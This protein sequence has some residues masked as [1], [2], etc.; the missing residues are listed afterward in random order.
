M[1]HAATRKGGTVT[2]S[3]F[4]ALATAC[5]LALVLTP[6]VRALAMRWGV[7]DLPAARKV[8]VAPTPLLGGVAVFVAFALAA[9]FWLRPVI[10]IQVMLLLAGAAAF[11]VV[12]L[13]DDV[14]DAGAWK[15]VLEAVI[16]TAIVWAGGFRV[17]LPWPVAGDVLAILWIV[18][19]ANAINCLDCTDGVASGVTAIAALALAGLALILGR[20]GVAV[21][22]CC[23]AG[24]ALGFLRY[25]FPPA[26]IFLG[27][28]GS[29]MMGFLLGGLGAV[30]V[31]PAISMEW[32]APLLILSVPVFD[33]LAVHVLRFR[34]GVSLRNIVTSTGRDH[35]P[36]RL[37]DAGLS[38][39]RVAWHVYRIC[40]LAGAS[41]LALVTWG[42][43]AAALPGA[44]FLAPYVGARA[45]RRPAAA[46]AQSD[47]AP[48]PT[49]ESS[50]GGWYPLGREAAN[51]EGEACD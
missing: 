17:P 47:A 20:T 48:S 16:V 37:L 38:P 49:S 32:I 41:G 7:L 44:V 6:V 30:L 2:T 8:H 40:A 50:S 1:R 13:I 9:V 39:A 12:G 31:A 33:F 35:L 46:D 27:D 42:P 14:W 45:R 19:V 28:A 26:R 24:A 15:L 51:Q 29:L 23:L 5:A 22:A 43:V 25:N 21:G 4:L 18:G 34:R 10:P 11:G 3:L 36:H